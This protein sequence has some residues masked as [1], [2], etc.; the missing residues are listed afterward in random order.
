MQIRQAASISQYERK[1]DSVNIY[2]IV[3]TYFSEL[4]DPSMNIYVRSAICLILYSTP[5]VFIFLLC[6]F[7]ISIP[8]ISTY[9]RNKYC[10]KEYPCPQSLLI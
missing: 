8:T 10:E 6:L 2:R 5:L 4:G 9:N 7:L 1:Y 3:I